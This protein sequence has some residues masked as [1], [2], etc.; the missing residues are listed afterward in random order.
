MRDGTP[1]CRL[2]LGD[3]VRWTNAPRGFEEVS[4]VGTVIGL[5]RRFPQSPDLAIDLIQIRFDE[6]TLDGSHEL[7]TDSIHA[8]AT[9]GG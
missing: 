7:W 4:L 5:R 6:L 3:R 2:R 9:H 1:E 8:E